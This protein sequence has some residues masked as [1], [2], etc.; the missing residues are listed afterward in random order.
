MFSISVIVMLAS[1][2]LLFLEDKLLWNLNLDTPSDFHCNGHS[3]RV[4]FLNPKSFWKMLSAD[5]F[6]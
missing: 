6:L 1:Y 5:A 3:G 2:V 4:Y